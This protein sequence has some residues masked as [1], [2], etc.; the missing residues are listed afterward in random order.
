M[1]S[2]TLWLDMIFTVNYCP[3]RCWQA[4]INSFS[5]NPQLTFI[6]PDF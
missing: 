2:V 1:I 3:N 4:Q 6:S 5:R